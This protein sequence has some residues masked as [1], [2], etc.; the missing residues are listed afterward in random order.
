M[1]TYSYDIT[2]NDDGFFPC[3]YGTLLDNYLSFK[4]TDNVFE[5]VLE[6]IEIYLT[7]KSIIDFHTEK[8]PNSCI[9]KSILF[10]LDD[11]DL[12]CSFYLQKLNLKIE[13]VQYLSIK[14]K[15]QNKV[16]WHSFG[17]FKR[18]DKSFFTSGKCLNYKDVYYDI[19]VVYSNTL[20]AYFREEDIVTHKY[21][22]IFTLYDS[23]NI[24]REKLLSLNLLDN[25]NINHY[26]SISS[27]FFNK[28]DYNNFFAHGLAIKDYTASLF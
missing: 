18:N 19:F 7:D 16:F 13:D 14:I 27:I 23:K 2:N 24:N 17:S 8:Y 5:I 12:S 26:N 9:T 6:N 1:N 15:Y 25:F 11:T 20:T 22:D 4:L 3:E 10:G 28:R 21:D